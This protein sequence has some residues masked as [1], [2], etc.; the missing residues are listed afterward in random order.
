MKALVWSIATYGCETWALKNEDDRRI[1]AFENKCIRMSLRIPWSRLMTDKQVYEVAQRKSELL[2]YAKSRKLR[3]LGYVMRLPY[4]SIKRSVVV[5]LA[6]G[7]R[8]RG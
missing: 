8:G 5:G 2:I 3:Y 7:A 4:D 1:Q 6:E